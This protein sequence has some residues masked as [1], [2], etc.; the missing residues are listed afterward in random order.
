MKI[1]GYITGWRESVQMDTAKENKESYKSRSYFKKFLERSF[2]ESELLP[3]DS[4]RS[5]SKSDPS[6]Y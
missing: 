3:A 2:L 4:W 1:Y 6:I 5:S